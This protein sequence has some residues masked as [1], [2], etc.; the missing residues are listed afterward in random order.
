MDA[1][2]LEDSKKVIDTL[3]NLNSRFEGRSVLLTGAAGFLGMQFAHYFAGLNNSGNFNKP[4]RLLGIDNFIRGKPVWLKEYG[5]RSNIELIEADISKSFRP[6][7]SF[8]FI[9]HA[10]SIAS[11]S[12]YREHPIETMDANVLGLRKLL[13][14]V[15][16]NPTESMLFFSSSEIYGDPIPGQI[17]TPETYLGN[18]SCIGPRACYDESK[19][20][21]ETLCDVFH[22]VYDVPVKI[23]RPFNNYGPGLK[24]SDKRVL[25]DFFRDVLAGRDIVLHSDGSPTRTF[26]YISDAITGYLLALLSDAEGEVFNIGADK[27]EISMSDL[28]RMVIQI[29]GKSLKIIHKPS[30]DPEYLKDNPQRRCPNINKA[31]KILGYE[32]SIEINEGLTNL[33]RWYKRN[34][35]VFEG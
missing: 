25:P 27:P 30:S 21:G 24:I 12:Y 28:A 22:R 33:Y 19:R 17:P 5:D 32:P 2:V 14:F 35:A 9:I 23:V 10:A 15:V 3:G 18:V 31:R 26:C 1:L 6:Y 20:F 4:V 13:D 16:K 8:D 7:G 11:P 34:S 29:S